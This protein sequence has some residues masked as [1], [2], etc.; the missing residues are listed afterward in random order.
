MRASVGGA[1]HDAAVDPRFEPLLERPTYGLAEVDRLLGLKASTARRWIDGYTRARKRYPPIVRLESTGDDTVT[2]GEFV[3][4][5]LLAEYRSRG[6]LIYKLR[7]AVERLR[8]SLNMRY[9]LAHAEPLL[10]VEG[11][12]LVQRVQTELKLEGSLRLVVIRN[13]QVVLAPESDSFT[14]SADYGE[15]RTVERIYPA[16]DLRQVVFDPLRRSGRPVV[17]SVATEVIAEQFRAGDPIAS[18]AEAY[19][20]PTADVE[21]A[22]RYELQAA[23]SDEA[24]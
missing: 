11:R 3:E 7:P 13:G 2:W 22:I 20:L 17:R 15:Q 24:A 12:E 23:E 8:E 21:A 6:A 9:P 1:C 19:E 10:D 5:R 16:P 18:I 14:R 4:M